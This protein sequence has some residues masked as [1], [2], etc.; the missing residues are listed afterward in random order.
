LPSLVDDLRVASSLCLLAIATGELDLNRFTALARYLVLLSGVL[1]LNTI[2]L[3]IPIGLQFS[4]P[5]VGLV[6]SAPSKYASGVI[7]VEF[8][9]ALCGT[10]RMGAPVTL[11]SIAYGK[12]CAACLNI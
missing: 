8:L 1:P 7:F 5:L 11:A 3:I 4:T 6:P 10:G 9:D 2:S 12:I